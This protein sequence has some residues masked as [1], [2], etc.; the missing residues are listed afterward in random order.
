MSFASVP[1]KL[2]YYWRVFG[3]ALSFLVFGLGAPF[4]FL[5]V[6]PL[7][8]ICIHPTERYMLCA[9]R[10]ICRVMQLFVLFM[11]VIQV[12]SLSVD[13]KQS[14]KKLQSRI[15][16]ANHPSILDVVFLIALIPNANCIV[17][18][19][20][21][22]TIVGGVIKSL[23]ISNDEN[24]ADLVEECRTSLERGECLII[25]P[26]GTRTPDEELLPFRK[27][28]ARIALE[29]DCDIVPIRIDGNKKTGLKK[30]DPM[31]FFHPTDKLR[32]VFSLKEKISV[33]KYKNVS[34]HVAI[35]RIVQDSRECLGGM[36]V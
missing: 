36:R 7:M 14:Y 15:V 8:K 32:Y 35:R 13:D 1:Q 30:G 34:P 28:F 23:Y 6:F 9:R 12:V 11:S 33:E 17:R 19:A 2:L 3:K 21:T 26:E 29:T 31:F 18:S 20:L 5:L 24:F 27:G 25:F 10:F 16:I 22:R 4:L